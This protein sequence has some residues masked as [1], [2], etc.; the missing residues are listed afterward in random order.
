[1]KTA[2]VIL[3]V[4]MISS[5]AVSCNDND[6]YQEITNIFATKIDSV[7]IVK[8]TMALGS[9]QEIKMFSTFTKGCEGIY[10]H[11]YQYTND[12]VRTLANFAFK[13]NAA[14]GDGTYV[15]GSRVNFAPTRK[16]TF[17]FKFFT[18]KDSAGEN[19]FL[20]KK[21]VVE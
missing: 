17:T 7:Q 8:N 1:M 21:I 13:S 14:C 10:S 11:D 4:L 16:G 2:A 18:G 20:V 15:D 5:L 12:S 9:S 19:T 3:P 6:D